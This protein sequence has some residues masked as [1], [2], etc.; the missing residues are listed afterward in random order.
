MASPDPVTSGRDS[1]QLHRQKLFVHRTG[2]EGPILG[3]ARYASSV[4]MVC[5]EDTLSVHT[6]CLLGAMDM[7]LS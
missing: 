1:G 4:W 6:D 5:I 3:G 7:W 2:M